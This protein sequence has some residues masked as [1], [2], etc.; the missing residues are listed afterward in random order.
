MAKHCGYCG[1]L[2][3]KCTDGVFHPSLEAQAKD[4]LIAHGNESALN[5]P[6]FLNSMV[7]FTEHILALKEAK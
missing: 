2:K 4:W 3:G 7:A 5:I 6:G 1:Q